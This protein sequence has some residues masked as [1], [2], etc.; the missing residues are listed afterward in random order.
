MTKE[1][2]RTPRYILHQMI[3]MCHGKEAFVEATAI[4]IS[5]SGI[6]CETTEHI[7]PG[8]R[9]Y[10]IIGVPTEKSTDQIQCEGVVARSDKSGERFHT[11]IAFTAMSGGAERNLKALAGTLQR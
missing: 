8:T 10:M 11:G 7:D 1:R 9:I 2:R 6:L 3:R 4:N 5:E